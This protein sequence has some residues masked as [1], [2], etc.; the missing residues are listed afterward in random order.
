METSGFLGT[1]RKLFVSTLDRLIWKHKRVMKLTQKMGFTILPSNFYSDYPSIQEIEGS[2][3]YNSDEPPF[4]NESFFIDKNLREVMD[5]FSPFAEEFNPPAEGDG[6]NPEF[7]YWQNRMFS[8]SDALAYY[9]LIRS[10]KPAN[11]IEIGSGFSTLVALEA[12]ERNGIGNIY[13]IEPYPK[14]FLRNEQ[15]INLL[16]M[17]A[18]EIQVQFLNDILKDGDF[19]FIDSTHTVKTGSDCLHIYLRLLPAVRR[20]IWVHAHDVF[21]P[22]G[23]P[24]HWLIEK[25]Y[26]WTEQYLLLA[27]LTD[28]PKASVKYGS[29]YNLARHKEQMET[30]M[31]GKYPAGGSSIWFEYRGNIHISR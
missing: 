29:A 12:V 8:H 31:N 24:K 6:E 3:E 20:N 16:P 9:C 11:I 22:W 7:F 4:E 21:L 2:F 18:Q 30:L 27:L 13:C 19:L 17:K 25:Q 23:M 14:E 10:I 28:N 15:R 1:L 26:F 5:S